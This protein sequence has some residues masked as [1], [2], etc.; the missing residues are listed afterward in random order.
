MNRGGDVNVDP[1]AGP[2]KA[3]VRTNKKAG[4]GA[5]GVFPILQQQKKHI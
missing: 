1:D 2:V 4:T 3:Q 5:L